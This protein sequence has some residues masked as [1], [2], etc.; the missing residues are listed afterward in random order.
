MR[1]KGAALVALTVGFCW[2]VI[3][4]MTANCA[5]DVPRMTI[6]ELEGRLGDPDLVIVDV[7]TGGSWE[8]RDAKIKGAVREDP[9][10]VQNWIQ[11]YPKDKI[12]VF[13]C[14]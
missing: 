14:S 5:G 12:L 6:E 3:I 13:Y 1:G 11:K 7:R 10:G 2:A 4:A 9:A 8:G